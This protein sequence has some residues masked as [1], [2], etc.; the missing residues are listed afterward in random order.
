MKA[1]HTSWVFSV[2]NNRGCDLLNAADDRDLL[3]LNDGSPTHH[4]F[5]YNTAEALDI[6]LASANV[7]PLCRWSVLNSIGSDHLPIKI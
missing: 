2:N 6:P 3:F 7:F 4:S 5:S 1:K